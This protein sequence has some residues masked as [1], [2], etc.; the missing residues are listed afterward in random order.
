MAIR[1]RED[2]LEM[3]LGVIAWL[4]SVKLIHLISS[5]TAPD[6]FMCNDFVRGTCRRRVDVLVKD[7]ILTN[8]QGQAVYSSIT[9]TLHRGVIHAPTGSGKT[10]IAAAIMA[11][12]GGRWVFLAPNTSLVKQAEKEI[13]EQALP[14]MAKSLAALDGDFTLPQVSFSTYSMASSFTL[15]QADGIIGDECHTTAARTRR[16]ALLCSGAKYRIGMSATP[17]DR[18]NSN[19]GLIIGLFGPVVYLIRLKDVE[20]AGRIARGQ[21]FQLLI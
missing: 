17:L 20:A 10:R 11:V 6:Q 1:S 9:G 14:A 21:V 13:I 7:K 16:E 2:R 18:Q 3:L 12:H 19:N 4:D 5:I 8:Y 15:E